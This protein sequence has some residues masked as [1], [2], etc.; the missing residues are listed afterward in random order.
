MRS[1]IKR[2][3][4]LVLATVAVLSLAV[5]PC[6][7]DQLV[8]VRYNMPVHVTANVNET[9]C[10]NNPGPKITLDG[11]IVLGGL[12]VEMVFENNLKGTHQA[13]VTFSTNVV[14]VP[15][16]SPIV[17]PKQPV[18]GGVGG[19]PHI[20][21]QFYNSH[22]QALTSE[23]YLGRCVQGLTLNNDFLNDVVGA[24][25]VSSDGCANHPGPVITFGGNLTLSGLKARFIFR[26]NLQ[27][28]HTAEAKSDVDIVIN[29]TPVTIPKQPVQGGAGGNPL[30][31]LQF[32][33]GDGTDIGDPNFLGRCNQL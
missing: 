5:L 13:V 21:I 9:G 26:N 12:Q 8:S 17:I 14:L 10:F 31:F 29:G 32:Q 27:G 3:S 18:Q 33:Q 25:T 19:N 11:V 6:R 24:T 28:T 2:R 1:I 7:A 15:L 30:I 20:W 23:I 16:N 4:G 22:N